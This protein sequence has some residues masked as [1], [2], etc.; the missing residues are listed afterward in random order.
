MNP[1]ISQKNSNQ[2]NKSF[3]TAYFT[4]NHIEN[5]EN[6]STKKSLQSSRIKTEKSSQKD[7]SLKVKERD[8][9]ANSYTK[10]SSI[11]NGRIKGKLEDFENMQNYMNQ[12]MYMSQNNF[13]NNNNFPYHQSMHYNTNFGE[14]NNHNMQNFNNDYISPYPYQPQHHQNM[15]MHTMLQNPIQHNFN[16]QH[17]PQDQTELLQLKISLLNFE[18]EN[19]ALKEKIKE[20]NNN[21][22]NL[23][24]DSKHKIESKNR[25]IETLKQKNENMIKERD[26]MNKIIDVS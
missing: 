26:K 20:L 15:N 18:T 24:K 14:M 25:E 17:T 10:S 21:F 1:L 22:K 16:N 4:E 23:E 19:V 7:L 9:N 5:N 11:K 2:N 3:K 8:S 13:Q 6:V 12:N